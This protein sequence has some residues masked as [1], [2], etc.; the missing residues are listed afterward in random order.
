MAKS[1]VYQDE[2]RLKHNVGVLMKMAN[3]LENEIKAYEAVLAQ[4]QQDI[5]R[6]EQKRLETAKASEQAAKSERPNRNE[7]RPI[8]QGRMERNKR[9]QQAS[10]AR[11]DNN[12]DKSL[13]KLRKETPESEVLEEK[14]KAARRK[15]AQKPKPAPS[16][17]AGEKV[18]ERVKVDDDNIIDGRKIIKGYQGIEHVEDVIDEPIIKKTRKPAKKGAK[19]NAMKGMDIP[20]SDKP[21]M[22]GASITVKD[23]SEKIGKPAAGIIKS[24]MKLGI[25]ATINDEIDFDTASLVASEYGVVLERKEEKSNEELLL[26][27]EKTDVSDPTKLV[28]RPPIVTVM[29]HVD[30]GKTSLLD[31]IRSTRVTEQEAGGITQHIGAYQVQINNRWIT[32]LDTPG[33]EAFTAMRARGAQVTDIAILVVAA[34]DGVMP[35]T[36]EAI[37][38]A[39]AAGVPIIVAINKIDKPGANPDRIKQQLTEYDL[40]PEDWGGDTICVPVSAKA[41]IGIDTLLEM[42]LLVADMQEL[43]AN[44]DRPAYGTII[45]A[46]LDKGMG[47][48]AT[49]LIQDGTL[50][51]GDV[52]LSGLTYGKV[53][54]LINDKGQRVNQAGPAMPVQVLGFSDVPSAGDKFYVVEEALAKKIVEERKNTIK[55]EQVK[56][57]QRLTLD[58][59]FNQI[60]EGEI[61]DLNIIVK[62]DVQG[63][64]EAVK[65]A[66]ERLSNDEVRVNVIHGG[67]GAITESD[68]LLASAS[69]AIIIGFNVRPE[70]G[71]KTAA[72]RDNIDIRLYRIIYDAIDDIKAAMKG[73]LAK[74]FEEV[75]LGHAEVRE[76]FKISNVGTVAGCYVIDGKITRNADARIIRDGIVVYEGKISSLKRFKDDAREVAA[77]YECGI[78]IERFNDIKE[79][80]IIEAYTQ[81]EVEP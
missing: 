19:N 51:V 45:E 26:E 46:Q 60:K 57:N 20:K 44:P 71:A 35:Q 81:Q 79:K 18:K 54:A 16:H 70:P 42:I 50:H 65:Q 30:H 13:E 40:I 68:V 72:A 75:V 10:P 49:A 21:I 63:S 69:N 38:H 33:H 9:Q 76:T 66:L 74:R 17:N 80:D 67:V 73:M 77:G 1:S 64:V 34:D 25:M 52:I 31:A 15:T 4:K 6:E 5:Q 2:R 47:P 11:R 27:L 22:I 56:H 62:A 24:L 36:V 58:D 43:R 59:L 3:S 8:Q 61:K 28:P 41:K 37:N 23:L 7:T 12:L 29:G 48:L 14:E 55:E 78:T 39:K 32:F 53:K